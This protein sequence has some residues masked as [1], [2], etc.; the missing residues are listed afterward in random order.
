MHKRF[1]DD[2]DEFEH[3]VRRQL[4]I[5]GENPDRPGLLETPKRAYKAWREWTRGYG[6]DIAALFKAFDDGAEGY[7]GIVLVDNIEFVSHCEH[8]LAPI[9]GVAH[10]AYIPNGK[11]VGLSK[12]ARVTDAF[13]S[14]FQVQERMT[15]QI[16][17][18]VQEHLEPLGCGVIVRAKHGCMC[19]RGVHQRSTQTTT[20][21]LRGCFL[22]DP[23]VKAEF[24]QLVAMAEGR[25]SCF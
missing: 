20:S 19:G 23:S 21:A 12:L 9:M 4:A 1:E 14:R 11:V 5:L 25:L 3:S 13:A 6:V 15:T 16:A 2:R 24:L 8:H 17:D 10:V 22:E 18:A 7:D